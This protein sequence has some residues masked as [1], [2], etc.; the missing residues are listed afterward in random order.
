[1]FFCNNKKKFEI[2][3]C[4]KDF[5]SS[6]SSELILFVNNNNQRRKEEK[7]TFLIKEFNKY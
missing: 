4:N 5:S 3:A 1:L 6:S 2:K 7:K